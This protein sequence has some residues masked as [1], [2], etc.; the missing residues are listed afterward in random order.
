MGVSLGGVAAGP[1]WYVPA[2]I[3]LGSRMGL[4]VDTR[5]FLVQTPEGS[6]EAARDT[7]AEADAW[8]N[9]G[10]AE[11]TWSE[12]R[13]ACESISRTAALV[14]CSIAAASLWKLQ[15]SPVA[16]CLG[17]RRTSWTP[18]RVALGPGVLWWLPWFICGTACCWNRLKVSNLS[19]GLLR[20]DITQKAGVVVRLLHS[21][22]HKLFFTFSENHFRRILLV[23]KTNMTAVG[24]R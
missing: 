2:A 7:G 4:G 14:A 3:P 8:S 18:G 20:D 21:F 23:K 12:E 22:T 17:S 24:L 9:C 16:W 5:P 10:R 15:R 19:D 6:V 11:A 13:D 1:L